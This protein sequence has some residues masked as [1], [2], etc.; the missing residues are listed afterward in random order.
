M[1]CRLASLVHQS[2]LVFPV[3][4]LL[5]GSSS[6]LPAGEAIDFSRDVAPILETHCVRC[7]SPNNAKGEIS[8]A[9][10][11]DLAKNGYLSAGDP[12]ASYLL[13]LITSSTGQKP[14]M[15]QEGDP[16]TTAQQTI[17]RNWIQ[18]GANWPDDVILRERSRVDKSWWSFQRLANTS[19]PEPRNL[20]ESWGHNPIDRFVYA[21]LAEN[22]LSPNPPAD[23]RT[24]I[25]R[26]YYDLIGLPPSPADVK[27]F[28]QNRDPLAYDRLIDRLL[29]SPQYGER[30]GR[31]WLDVVRFGE[32]NGFERN[33]LIPDLWPF[34]DYVIQSINEDKP[35][36]LLIR[37]HLAGDVFG[38][39]RPESEIGS[40]FLVA[41]PYDDV[42]NQDP[43]QARQ[44]RANTID[45]MIRAAGEAF[46][47][48]TIGCARCHDHK[49]DPIRQSDYYSWYATFAGV[50]HGR[51]VVATPG[52]KSSLA[53]RRQPL[54][55]KRNALTQERQT[56]SRSIEERGNANREQHEKTWTRPP[57]D[58]RG[59]VETFEPTTAKFVRLVSEGQD[60]NL[61]NRN[62]FGIDEFE[63][64][65]A[66]DP[67]VN[68][69]LA[70]NGAKATGPSRPI[71]DTPGVYGPQKAIDGKTGERFLA[72]GGHLTIELAE[73]S[74]IN[75]V[76]FSSARGEEKPDQRK[77]NF[78]AEYR[79]EVSE[80]GSTWREVANSSDRKPVNEA[81][82][83]HRLRQLETK[84]EDQQRM[85][86]LDREIAEVNRALAAIPP[87][88]TVF[89]GTR[90]QRDA[91][92]PFHI[93]L[94]GSPERKGE[95][96]LPASLSTLSE[97][98]PSYKLTVDSSESTRRLELADWLVED[99][100]PLTPRV[101]AN[102][103]WHYHFGTGLVST[104]NDFGSMGT[105]PS[106]PALLDWL[107]GEL[108]RNGWRIKSMHRLIMTSQTYQQSGRYRDKPARIDSDAR[109][110]WRFPPRRLSAEEIRDSILQV[111]GVLH[112]DMGG[113]GFRLY[114]FMQDNVCT[115]V[116]LDRPGPET[117]RRAIYHQNARAAVVDLMTEFDQPDC[118][119][120]APR[121][122]ETIS[123][124]QALTMLNHQFTLDMADSF[125]KR[126]T[127]EA[128]DVVDAQIRLA[129]EQCYSRS[130][131]EAE[132]KSCRTFVAEHGLPAFCR[133]MFNTS[134]FIYLQ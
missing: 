7:H 105:L 26:A 27:A 45:E 110:L 64:W 131:T 125:A 117:Y 57:V 124:L 99:E 44:I 103:L 13:E 100:N 130:V 108:R 51:R 72:T 29:N 41:G 52:E 18:Q 15:P 8:L 6:E 102:R 69:A 93:F 94:G 122:S 89:V 114:H 32:S 20:P 19:P 12:S 83:K 98:A 43:V 46:L 35:F 127:R 132:L 84:P 82:R 66:T 111:A 5:F 53:N 21:K 68:V 90:S 22:K 133:V 129:F 9:T 33:V 104:P 56:L 11:T 96:V 2:R 79:I 42:G 10:V 17:L 115:Y 88:Q 123:P 74:S 23:R 77:F 71:Q 86:E 95:E 126:L 80:D 78:V 113:P 63:I 112:A 54:E 106:H 28:E 37:E 109:L 55:A 65:T 116:P 101:L 134:E 16:L 91:Q 47:G 24:L 67:N 31:H 121:R 30:W 25:R 92:G 107:A 36:D 34:R 85:K 97:S 118:A 120:S 81:H 1:R 61:A 58:R 70:S 59:T 48:L 40:A 39:G 119:F 3:I 50:R 49:F 60:A 76:T 4:F 128:G 38:N 87:L 75:R 62:Q 14:E 73:P